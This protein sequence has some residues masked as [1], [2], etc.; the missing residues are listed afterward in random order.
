MNPDRKT[1]LQAVNY[2][3]D[4]S[5][6][7]DY[8]GI[9]KRNWMLFFQASFPDPRTGDWIDLDNDNFFENIRQIISDPNQQNQQVSNIPANLQ[10]LTDD[11]ERGK[12]KRR[13]RA[14]ERRQKTEI[15]LAQ[16]Q[17]AAHWQISKNQTI[18]D[19]DINPQLQKLQREIANDILTRSTQFD[20]LKNINQNELAAAFNSKTT[21]ENLTDQQKF[22]DEVLKPS[23][24]ETLRDKGVASNEAQKL[25]NTI[26]RNLTA[27]SKTQLNIKEQAFSLELKKSLKARQDYLRQRAADPN[28]QPSNIDQLLYSQAATLEKT[29][30]FVQGQISS[31]ASLLRQSG[32]NP[33]TIAIQ[34]THLINS[35]TS[36]ADRP[37]FAFQNSLEF[38][39]NL[40]QI[41]SNSLEA[42]L[43]RQLRP[44]LPGLGRFIPFFRK[45]EVTNILN[46]F[47]PGL[48]NLPDSFVN[49]TKSAALANYGGSVFSAEAGN[50]LGKLPGYVFRIIASAS[51]EKTIINKT[52]DEFITWFQD[53]W[54]KHYQTTEPF[55]QSKQTTMKAYFQ[56]LQTFRQTH[57][58]LYKRFVSYQKNFINIAWGKMVASFFLKYPDYILHAPWIF[59]KYA[60]QVQI[61]NKWEIRWK[62]L[63]LNAIVG[64][65]PI[66]GNFAGFWW[67]KDSLG[68]YKNPWERFKDKTLEKALQKT[69][70]FSGN[71]FKF[72]GRKAGQNK[73][74]QALA[75]FGKKLADIASTGGLG[76]LF[77]AFYP[78]FKGTLEKV[79]NFFLLGAVGIFSLLAKYGTGALIGGGA[80]A[81]IGVAP[82]FMAGKA[83]FLATVGP[84]NVFAIIPS[85]IAGGVV[86]LFSIGVGGGLGILVTKIGE[87]LGFSGGPAAA[88]TT[89]AALSSLSAVN[90]ASAA[91]IVPVTIG[92]IGA[93]TVITLMITHSAFIVP[94]E[95]APLMGS[96]YID[97]KKAV[98]VGG[99]PNPNNVQNSVVG[100]ALTYAIEIEFKEEI[101]TDVKILDQTTAVGD[102]GN[103]VETRPLPG[104]PEQRWS[105]D[106]SS[107]GDIWQSPPFGLNQI[108]D[109]L[110]NTFISNTVT[111]IAIGPDGQEEKQTISLSFSIGS[112]PLPEAAQLASNL[113]TNLI[114]CYGGEYL[115]ANTFLDAGKCLLDNGISQTVVNEISVSIAKYQALQC[116]GFVRAVAA[117]TGQPLADI[118]GNAKDYARDG[119][120][121]F[122]H[123]SLEIKNIKPGDIFIITKGEWGHM[124]VVIA[125]SGGNGFLVAEAWGL[126]ANGKPQGH[127]RTRTYGFDFLISNYS[128][129]FGFLRHD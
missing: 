24:E 84:L 22:Q 111:V 82:A 90:I 77:F 40:R 37:N 17:L 60:V 8:S 2:F 95:L 116:V 52:P 3:I 104:L 73:L 129:Q 35:Q 14:F 91:G 79:K 20:D 4:H 71:L 36:L 19:N 11:W 89:E 16:R 127:V 64:K 49:A 30:K 78:L 23:L 92:G 128:S 59:G 21:L 63:L 96:R 119:A 48:Q 124:A 69:F 31:L 115:N 65:V 7:N 54:Q 32:L 43:E 85:V 57:P 51:S 75:S 81:L 87:W 55:S 97:I 42:V 28:Y 47:N 107:P 45:S 106:Q 67:K 113:I 70:E 10:Q 88:A 122:W 103:G 83:V 33:T 94:E 117:G 1:L 105:L 80:G 99:I 39:Q 5:F 108:P 44:R 121:Y 62:P 114:G 12:T 120:G 26:A 110:Q 66:I 68:Y 102:W 46:Q 74:G 76:A 13:R 86:W 27:D 93:L 56:F 58:V 118:A 6:A 18:I 41:A 50:P 98:D 9:D 112:P 29:R 38:K 100:Q 126:D 25:S 109:T 123:P 15:D 53:Y 34:T 61:T 125:P 101:L 72:L